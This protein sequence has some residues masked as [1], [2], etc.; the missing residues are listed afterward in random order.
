MLK[1]L[2]DTIIWINYNA[3]LFCHCYNFN[4]DNLVSITIMHLIFYVD[5]FGY[6]IFKLAVFPECCHEKYYKVFFSAQSQNLCI[7]F[8]KIYYAF[9]VLID[10]I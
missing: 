5:N 10:K 4:C 1:K 8:I 7:D 3:L 6:K 2:I 9:K